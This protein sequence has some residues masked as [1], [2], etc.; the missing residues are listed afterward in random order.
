MK[1]VDVFRKSSQGRRQDRART[2]QARQTSYMR[3][4]AHRLLRKVQS[5][6][7]TIGVILLLR[8]GLLRFRKRKYEKVEILERRR[9]DMTNLMSAMVKR[10]I[11][12][13]IMPRMSLRFPSMIS[14]KKGIR[15]IE[16]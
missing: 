12:V 13:H 8:R 16:P 5:C 6:V 10:R 7:D 14:S 1:K 2:R 9:E 15:W 11:S 4:P 3:N